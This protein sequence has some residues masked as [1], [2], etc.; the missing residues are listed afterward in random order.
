MKKH[1]LS[2]SHNQ[3]PATLGCNENTRANVSPPLLEH[4]LKMVITIIILMII[5]M[6]MIITMLITTVVIITIIIIIIITSNIIILFMQ[7]ISSIT[8]Y[9]SRQKS[10]KHLCMSLCPSAMLRCDC[11]VTWQQQHCKREG[12]GTKGSRMF[13]SVSRFLSKIAILAKNP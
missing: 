5:K 13:Q 10:L 6:I 11:K 4:H 3:S 12:A 9:N 7:T 2:F 1:K 8:N